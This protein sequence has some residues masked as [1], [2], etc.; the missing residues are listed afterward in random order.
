MSTDA[1]IEEHWISV[2]VL[3]RPRR[4]PKLP[5]LPVPHAPTCFRG[6]AALAAHAQS[7]DSPRHPGDGLSA[8]QDGRN[9][10]A[11]QARKLT[12]PVD[13][14]ALLTRNMAKSIPGRVF[15]ENVI[16]PVKTILVVNEAT[17]FLRIG[18]IG[19]CNRSRDFLLNIHFRLRELFFL[20]LRKTAL[21]SDKSQSR[22]GGFGARG[23]A[24]ALGE[25]ASHAGAQG[26]QPVRCRMRT[27]RWR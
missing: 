5:A 18:M 1:W 7:R 10:V 17:G 24:A 4:A 3:P 8:R 12:Q 11:Q 19:R 14:A 26:P 25:T 2:A 15:D 21:C 9:V 22:G 16:V 23:R 6:N 13:R 27:S 20:N